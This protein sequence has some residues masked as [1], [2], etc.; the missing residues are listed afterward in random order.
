MGK[1]F[2]KVTVSSCITLGAFILGLVGFI[3]YLVNGSASGYFKGSNEASVILLSILALVAL[4]ASIALSFFDFKGVGGKA[5]PIVIGVLRIASAILIV[6][7]LVLFIT[8]RAQGL[9]YILASDDNVKDEIQTPE[10][11]ASAYGAIAGFI[12][13]ILTW[14]VTLVACFFKP[15]KELNEVKKLKEVKE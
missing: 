10:N 8:S 3:I 5:V 1:I 15:Q 2:K 14:V 13:Y 11:M 7:A 9:A 4:A 12:F 6:S